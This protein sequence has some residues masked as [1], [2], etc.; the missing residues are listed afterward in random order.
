MTGIASAKT[1]RVRVRRWVELVAVSLVGFLVAHWTRHDRLP[2][3]I[4]WSGVYNVMAH[5]GVLAL[6]TFTW[7]FFWR[8]IFRHRYEALFMVPVVLAT[9]AEL[10]Q[11]FTPGHI[12]DLGG[13][14]CNLIGSAMGL[15][16][17]RSA[18]LKSREGSASG[19][20]TRTPVSVA[21]AD[22]Q[23]SASRIGALWNGGKGG[24]RRK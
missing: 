14:G 10:G 24:N 13:L 6:W 17:G 16:F 12:P 11:S 20:S 1:K 7:C 9:V 18:W 5:I 19:T 8:D 21:P 15:Y 4:W 2:R 3:I 22:R 23:R